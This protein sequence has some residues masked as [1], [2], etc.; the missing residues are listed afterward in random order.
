MAEGVAEETEERAGGK[1][2]VELPARLTVFSNCRDPNHVEFRDK[3]LELGGWG[4]G[5]AL[6]PTSRY[7]RVW[8]RNA[9]GRILRSHSGPT[10]VRYFLDQFF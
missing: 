7:Y 3:F 10:A 9:D 8:E 6:I 1:T 2:E 5:L 4:V